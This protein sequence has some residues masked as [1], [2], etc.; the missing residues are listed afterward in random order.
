[1]VG[2][3]RS[4]MMLA[5]LSPEI[6]A[7]PSPLQRGSARV[8]GNRPNTVDNLVKI[9]GSMRLAPES[10]TASIKGMPSFMFKLILSTI[11]MEFVTTMPNK[12]RTPISAGNERGV[13]VNANT[14][15]TDEMAI[16]ITNRTIAACLKELNWTTIVT[17][18]NSAETIMAR[19]ID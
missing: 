1:M 7:P 3:N 5:K 11:N 2:I 13:L 4:M 8:M 15:K 17:R 16:G 14:R 18:I 19:R 6:M 12:D 9:I 10:A